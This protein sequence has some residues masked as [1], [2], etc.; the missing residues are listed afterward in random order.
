MKTEGVM[1]TF[2]MIPKEATSKLF[3]DVLST[4]YLRLS[5]EEISYVSTEK[6]DVFELL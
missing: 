2:L 4:M 3:T 1:V 6:V 5:L